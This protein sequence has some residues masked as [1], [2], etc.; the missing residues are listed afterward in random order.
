MKDTTPELPKE[1]CCP[2][3]HQL[4]YD[5]VLAADGITYEREALTMYFQSQNRSPMT[6]EKI[7]TTLIPNVNM[8]NRV[9]RLLKEHPEWKNEV[10]QPNSY[11]NVM[12]DEEIRMPTS[13][14]PEMPNSKKLHCFFILLGIIF[15]LATISYSPL[16]IFDYYHTTPL[17]VKNFIIFILINLGCGQK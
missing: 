12:H 8:K 7:P 13:E 14:Q 6:R 15:I 17:H 1:L 2:I 9:R 10:Y 4:F 3:T 11:D 16:V 5:P